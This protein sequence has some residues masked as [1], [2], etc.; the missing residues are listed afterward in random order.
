MYESSIPG[1][2]LGVALAGAHGFAD[3]VP[4][5]R[6]R[7]G[8][9][10]Y[11]GDGCL[12]WHDRFQNTVVTAGKNDLLTQYFKGSAYTAAWSVG[13]I[14]NAGFAA[15]AAADTMGSHGGWAESVA[16]ANANRPD[17]VLGSA[18]SGSIDNSAAAASFSINAA[19]TIRGAFIASNN[20]KGG[21]AGTLYSAGTFAASRSVSPGDTLN[22][23][24]TLTAN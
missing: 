2:E 14:D 7:Y 3:P 12:K 13:L 20:A 9:A 23:T 16:Y 24:V 8:V 5:P 22:I 17:L 21:A 11:S 19:A 10:C 15:I 6:A 18:A 4:V 1:A